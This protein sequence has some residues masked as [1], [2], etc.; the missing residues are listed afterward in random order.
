MAVYNKVICLIFTGLS[1]HFYGLIL[2]IVNWWFLPT[3]NIRKCSRE[4]SK[5]SKLS[6]QFANICA[7]K[8][9]NEQKAQ[10]EGSKGNVYTELLHEHERLIHMGVVKNHSL[11][12]V[13]LIQD[14]SCPGHYIQM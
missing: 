11:G 1:F 13:C 7:K 6:T 5:C 14:Y 9:V 3:S 12:Y 4:G 10:T 2:L 8:S